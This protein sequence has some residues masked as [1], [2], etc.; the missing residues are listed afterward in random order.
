MK[1]LQQKCHVVL[2]IYGTGHA[3]S[4]FY[5]CVDHLNESYQAVFS[6]FFF[7]HIVFQSNS[8]FLFDLNSLA[9]LSVED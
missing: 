4:N 9:Y 8:L 7:Q 1:A 2:F 5:I 6:L 3:G